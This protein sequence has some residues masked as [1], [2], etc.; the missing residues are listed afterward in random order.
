MRVA[1]KGQANAAAR[2]HLERILDRD[3]VLIFVERRSMCEQREI[4]F[5]GITRGGSRRVSARF[6]TRSPFRLELQFDWTV[7]KCA[8]PLQVLGSQ[9]VFG[10]RRSGSGDRIEVVQACQSG[11]G[12]VVVPANKHGTDA[13]RDVSNFVRARAIANHVAQ[14]GHSVVSWRGF[15]ARGQSL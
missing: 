5:R 11:A 2:Q 13:A 7:W 12:F 8:Q 4:V 10:P 15:K 3:H 14:I 6:T 1:E 9:N